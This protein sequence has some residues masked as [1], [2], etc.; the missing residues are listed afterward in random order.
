VVFSSPKVENC[1]RKVEKTALKNT[2]K[3]FEGGT[4]CPK[5]KTALALKRCV[6]SK[7]F[8]APKLLEIKSWSHR[9][10]FKSF[11]RE[12]AE[13]KLKITNLNAF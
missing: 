1:R 7:N 3:K 5:V 2:L 6:E 11:R 10:I 8:I 12:T 4:F 9:K 13:K